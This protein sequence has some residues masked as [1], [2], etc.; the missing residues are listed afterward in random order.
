MSIVNY[1]TGSFLFSSDF[2]EG[3]VFPGFPLLAS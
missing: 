3:G 2:R 1:V